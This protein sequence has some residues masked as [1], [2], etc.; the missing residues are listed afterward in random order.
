MFKVKNNGWVSQAHTLE[1]SLRQ[2]CPMSAA[3]FVIVVEM[4][5]IKIRKADNIKGIQI[6][7]TEHRIIQ[8]ADD[9]TIC[10]RD[11]NS[12]KHTLDIIHEFS[13]HA[14]P[15]LSLTKTKGILLGPL[16]DLGLRR[17]QNITWTGNPVKVLGLYIGHKKEKCH[18]LYWT[19]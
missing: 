16:K 15:K 18:Y 5:A 14:G 4:L 2:G 13:N 9:A 10:M 7:D 3:F 17:Y 1:R 19:Y 11:L 6:G 8:Y 12:V